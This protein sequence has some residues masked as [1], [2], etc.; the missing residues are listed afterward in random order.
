[1]IVA[2]AVC[3]G[4]GGR[5]GSRWAQIAC[6]LKRS[7]ASILYCMYPKV[8]LQIQL[9][10]FTSREL[11]VGGQTPALL[12]FFLCFLGPHLCHMKVPRL[13]IKS[14]LQLPAS[15][16]ATAMKD[17]SHVC[18]LHHSSRQRQL[19]N[20]LSEARDRTLILMDTSWVYNLLSHKGTS[21]NFN[22]SQPAC[23]EHLLY[24]PTLY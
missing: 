8:K 15:T 10:S 22:S 12:F 13:G 14:K 17:L 11:R 19:L 5:A 9:Q 18:D 7:T 20:P 23:F 16:T 2:L 6:Q 3:H 1:M 24:V 21:F 4:A